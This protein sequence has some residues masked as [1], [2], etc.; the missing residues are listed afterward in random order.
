[1]SKTPEQWAKEWERQSVALSQLDP[2][3]LSFSDMQIVVTSIISQAMAQAVEELKEKAAEKA[4][5]FTG[6]SWPY[7]ASNAIRALPNPYQS[8]GE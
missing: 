4:G 6:L 3:G 2:N 7:Q 1:M 8:K 5:S